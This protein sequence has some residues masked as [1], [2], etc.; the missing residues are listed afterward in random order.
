MSSLITSDR[1]TLVIGLGVSG[2]SVARF[3]ARKNCQFEIAD[4]RANPPGLE[5]FKSEFPEV[6]VH[7]GALSIGLLENFSEIVV[8][9][10]LDTRL[11]PFKEAKQAGISIVGDIELFAR[12]VSKPV[13]AITGSNAKTTVTTLVAEMLNGAGVKAQLGGNIGVPVLDLVDK[14]VD[15]FVLELSSFQLDTTTSLE[16][17][18]ATVLNISEDHMDRYNSFQH[19]VQSKMRVFSNCDIAVINRDDALAQPL[20]GREV[21]TI[22]FGIGEPDLG[23]YGLKKV[24]EGYHLVKNEGGNL[25]MLISENDL[26][27]KG[28]HNLNNCLSAIALCDV[29]ISKFEIDLGDCIQSLMNFHGLEHR[30]EYVQ[31]VAGV[32]FINDSKGTNLGSTIAAVKG[33]GPTVSGKIKLI[34]GGE[35]KG[36]DFKP[37]GPVL[38]QFVDEISIFGKDK[39]KIQQDLT[40]T[41]IDSELKV[42]VVEDLPA[43]L[44]VLVEESKSGD[45][46]LL[47]PACASWDMYKSYEVRGQHFKELVAELASQEGTLN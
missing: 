2:M 18:A 41:S 14:D 5:S 9:P 20:I 6:N 37:L 8:S 11:S 24:E 16:P 44:D 13:I 15:I 32:D 12:V 34:L 45:L 36:A 27:L 47:S 19:Y 42:H 17:L 31:S 25:R 28:L 26:Q 38:N 33:L 7:L 46:I 22:S 35:S 4:T 29:A 10:G 40:D 21:Q 1:K 39:L 3:L 23:Q 30:C 43:A